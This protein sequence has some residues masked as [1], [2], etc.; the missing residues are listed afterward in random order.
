MSP[1][2]KEARLE[3]ILPDTTSLCVQIERQAQTLTALLD[4]ADSEQAVEESDLDA[5]IESEVFVLQQ[6]RASSTWF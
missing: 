3:A 1:A 5:R 2:E 4:E 6:A